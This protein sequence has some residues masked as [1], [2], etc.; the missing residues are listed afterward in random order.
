MSSDVA[1]LGLMW[2]WE[3]EEVKSSGVLGYKDQGQRMELQNKIKWTGIDNPIHFKVDT[4]TH[5][6]Q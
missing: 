2:W 4:H 5:H 3:Q 1:I 6:V